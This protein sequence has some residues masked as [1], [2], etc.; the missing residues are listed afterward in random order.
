[1]KK[2]TEGL[3]LGESYNEHN[4]SAANAPAPFTQGSLFTFP[5]SLTFE[6][7][8]YRRMFFHLFHSIM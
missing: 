5:I 1:M 2:M 6:Q 3:F 8:S 7:L 4:P